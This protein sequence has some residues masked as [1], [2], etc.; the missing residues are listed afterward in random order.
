M[1]A[2]AVIALLGVLGAFGRAV[3]AMLGGSLGTAIVMQLMMGAVLLVF[4]IL[5]VR[6]FLDARRSGAV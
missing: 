6:S 2:A 4:L 3:P 1:H 5:C